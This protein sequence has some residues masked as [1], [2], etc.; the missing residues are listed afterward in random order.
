MSLRPCGPLALL[1]VNGKKTKSEA[2]FGPKNI[3]SARP[4]GRRAMT[5]LSESCILVD[6]TGHSASVLRHSA[7]YLRKCIFLIMTPQK[8]PKQ[9]RAFHGVSRHFR[10]FKVPTKLDGGKASLIWAQWTWK[11]SPRSIGFDAD[12]NGQSRQVQSQIPVHPVAQRFEIALQADFSNGGNS[13][14]LSS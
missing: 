3:C 2:K 8:T 6:Y 12:E 13:D 1:P 9:K 7:V 10:T 11:P 14:D 4:W 5:L